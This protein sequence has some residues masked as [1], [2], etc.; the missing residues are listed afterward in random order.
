[1]LLLAG[2]VVLAAAPLGAPAAP[3]AAQTA[4]FVV[5]APPA[6][7][8]VAR[9]IRALTPYFLEPAVDLTGAYGSQE[10]IRV[11]LLEESS[12]MAKQ[13]PPWYSAFADE[14]TGTIVLFPARTPS[15]P[16]DGLLPLLRHEATRV[17]V[18][19]CGAPPPGAALVRRGAG[20]DGGAGLE[21]RGQDALRPGGPGRAGTKGSDLD[22]LFDGGPADVSRAYALAGGWSATSSTDSAPPSRAGRSRPWAKGTSSPRRSTG[23]PAAT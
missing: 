4:P 17:L 12:P 20:D 9:R 13:V 23:R 16:D 15:Y 5:K 18:G 6:L 11:V 2:A 22:T 21:V 3:P 1:M 19:A 8:P 14:A 10:P 7:E